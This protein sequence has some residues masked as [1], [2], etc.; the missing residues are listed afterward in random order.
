MVA[1]IFMT[2]KAFLLTAALLVV[3]LLGSI[4][5]KCLFC[6]REL[7]GCCGRNIAID[8]MANKNCFDQ[9]PGGMTFCTLHEISVCSMQKAI[10]SGCT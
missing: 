9:V 10:L 8:S 6:C 2:V 4:W 7:T 3:G 1:V 5:T